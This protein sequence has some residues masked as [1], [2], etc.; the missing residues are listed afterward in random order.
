[1]NR[2]QPRVSPLSRAAWDTF[3]LVRAKSRG[4]YTRSFASTARSSG[5]IMFLPS[6]SMARSA[7]RSRS[8]GAVSSIDREV[9]L[10]AQ[11]TEVEGNALY[12]AAS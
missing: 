7:T 12:V 5:V 11:G 10:G 9:A 1:M 3:P 4:K 6:A 8:G 2:V